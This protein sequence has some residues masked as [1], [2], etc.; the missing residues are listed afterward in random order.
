MPCGVP[1]WWQEGPKG[2]ASKLLTMYVP[3]A[4]AVVVVA[5]AVVVAAVVVVAH[6]ASVHECVPHQTC[7]HPHWT[8]ANSS[9][10]C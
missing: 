4:V 2:D 10:V 8:R 5:V 1:C 3:V 6:Q 7:A 9:R